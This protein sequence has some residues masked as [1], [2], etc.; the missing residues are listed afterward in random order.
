MLRKGFK[1]EDKKSRE[2][3][4]SEALSTGLPQDVVTST[5]LT[6]R[7]RFLVEDPLFKYVRNGKAS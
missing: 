2:V 3:L 5:L 4:G 1:K 7:E 6:G